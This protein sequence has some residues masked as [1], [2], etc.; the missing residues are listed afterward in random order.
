MI[1]KK[2]KTLDK[3][4]VNQDVYEAALDRLRYLYKR[5]DRVVVSF[6]GG[7]DSTAV[8]NLCVQVAREIGRLPVDVHF[9]DEECISPDTADYVERVFKSADINMTWYCIP[10]KHRN[11]CSRRQPY[12]HP[13]NV[14]ERDLWVR[15]MP[16]W[17]T[18]E[19]PGFVFGMSMPDCLHLPFSGSRET[20]AML[21]GIRA[22]ESMR[23][24][25]ISLRSEID[26]YI[27]QKDGSAANFYLCDPIYDW[28]VNDVWVSPLKFNWDYNRTY[29]RFEAMGVSRPAQR[30]GPPFGEE[31]LGLLH[32]WG[33][34]YPD[35]WHK[36]TA[37]VPGAATAARYALTDLYGY[38]LT[39]PP[40]GLTW[41]EWAFR[42]LDLY[43]EPWRTQVANS[44][45][46]VIARHKNKTHRPIPDDDVDPMSGVSWRSLAHIALKGDF[47]RRQAGM[48]TTRAIMRARS[49]GLT[50]EQ[51]LEVERENDGP[52]Y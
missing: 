41:R 18:T 9:Y 40:N 33:I 11:A 14:A 6:S 31:P 39:A 37:R 47:K 38:R 46:K 32:S 3:H 16:E 24:L 2:R 45:K 27:H 23:R 20:V 36:M 51:L 13:W 8:L 12:W 1:G 34:C 4:F 50:L 42:I 19:M 26:N 35:L 25:S 22:Q 44:V 21:R 5:F 15:A 43:D 28:T 29:D 17:A 49:L 52:R 10:I 30:V 7:K 48:T